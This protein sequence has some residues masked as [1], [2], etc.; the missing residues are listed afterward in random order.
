VRTKF[1]WQNGFGAFSYSQSSLENVKRYIENQKYHHAVK[2]FKREYQE[3][4]SM[5][6][7]DYNQDYLF[8]WIL[9][10]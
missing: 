6:D 10:K 4:L 5:F 1:Q 3:F 7:I 2:T 8:D 9:E